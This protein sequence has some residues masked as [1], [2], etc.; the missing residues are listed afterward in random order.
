[1]RAPVSPVLV[2]P[3]FI[4]GG[5]GFASLGVMLGSVLP[6][7][8]A[9]QGVGVLLW[10]IMIFISGA[11]PPPEVLNDAMRWTAEFMPLTHVVRLIQDPW[12]GFG[13]NMRETLIVAGMAAGA[14]LISL[15]FFRW[16]SPKR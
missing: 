7:A 6:T 14:A 1:L 11:G 3:A 12:L 9:A 13:W 4:L 15:R 10:F 16:E 2:L 5:A 8:R